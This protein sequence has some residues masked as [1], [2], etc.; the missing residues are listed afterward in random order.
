MWNECGIAKSRG[1]EGESGCLQSGAPLSCLCR[2]SK[3][4][5]PRFLFLSQWCRRK[6]T[7]ILIL[8]LNTFSYLWALWNQYFPTA[9][10]EHICHVC[11]YS[12]PTASPLSTLHSQLYSSLAMLPL[13]FILSMSRNP[14]WFTPS[15][16]LK[17]RE[18]WREPSL[19]LWDA[20]GWRKWPSLQS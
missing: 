4:S 8:I 17:T 1:A 9:E 3:K 10:R 2:C 5:L 12:Q 14:P 16:P 13:H 20:V 11:P 7:G 18:V 15:D 19:P 6:V